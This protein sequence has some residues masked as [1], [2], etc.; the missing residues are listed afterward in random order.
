MDDFDEN[1]TTNAPWQVISP[2]WEMQLDEGVHMEVMLDNLFQLP[3]DL[4]VES[5]PQFMTL[6]PQM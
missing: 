1:W 3:Y 2:P 5:Q 4:I 6:G